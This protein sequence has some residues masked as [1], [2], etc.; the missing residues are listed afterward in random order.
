MA[1]TVGGLSFGNLVAQPLEYDGE[2]RYGR[3]ATAWRLQG[4]LNQ[5]QWSLLNQTYKAWRD[6]RINDEDSRTSNS[7]GT[8]VLFSGTAAGITWTSIPCWFSEAPSGESKGT[9]VQCDFTLIN[10][11]EALQALQAAEAQTA[12][13]FGTFSY[14]ATLKLRRPVETFAFVPQ[15]QQTVSGKHYISGPNQL[16]TAYTVEGETDATGWGQVLSRYASDVSG[17]PVNG[18]YF[19]TSPPSAVAEAKIVNGV[20]T[21]TYVVSLE[22]IQVIG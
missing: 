16:T 9:W 8:T 4:L 12:Y 3:T 11:A 5:T 1:V 20:R 18:Q 19:P 6:S 13:T 15:I 14:G 21:D 17:T 10:A 22:L 7:V 2:A